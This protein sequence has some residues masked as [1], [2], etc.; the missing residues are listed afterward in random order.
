M[1]I[2]NGRMMK[3][4]QK[5]GSIQ[6]NTQSFIKKQTQPIDE[7][8]QKVL[9][10]NI[11]KLEANEVDASIYSDLAN[12]YNIRSATFE[13]VK[14]I[15]Q[16]LYG[17]GVMTLKDVVTLTFDYDR[18][19]DYIKQAAGGMA[20]SHFTMYQTNEDAFGRRDWI[21]EFEARAAKDRQYGNLFI[22]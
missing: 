22:L 10:Q 17:A 5:M 18:A 14:E 20:S 7:G 16:Q 19:T 11:E 12:T 15:A 9:T 2:H 6:Q 13:E 1:Y 3:L 4:I 21:A 8:F